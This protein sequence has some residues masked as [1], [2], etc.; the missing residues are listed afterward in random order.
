MKS[1]SELLAA[2]DE[3]I[4]TDAETPSA[5]AVR[6]LGP[7]RLV[8]FARGRGF[9]TYRDLGNADAQTIR[10]LAREALRTFSPRGGL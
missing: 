2:Y 8:T 1:P 7:L 10:R 4:R 6:R 9:I 5:I 3:E